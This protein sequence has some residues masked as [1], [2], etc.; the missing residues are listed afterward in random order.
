MLPQQRGFS[1][2]FSVVD[3]D[4]VTGCVDPEA[5]VVL[6]NGNV[7]GAGDVDEL[8]GGEALEELADVDMGVALRA[9]APTVVGEAPLVAEKLAPF[10]DGG[11]EEGDLFG[12]RE[13]LQGVRAFVVAAGEGEPAVGFARADVF[14]E[15]DAFLFGVLLGFTAERAFPEFHRLGICRIA[16]AIRYVG[17]RRLGAEGDGGKGRG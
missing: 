2:V 11:P 3:A 15:E 9:D 6:G 12:T 10:F 5:G 14:E 16:G 4:L 1:D 17:A 8:A 7:F 13:F